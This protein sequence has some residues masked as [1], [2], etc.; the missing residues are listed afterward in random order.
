M[1]AHKGFT[2]YYRELHLEYACARVTHALTPRPSSVAVVERS[3]ADEGMVVAA[4]VGDQEVGACI[5]STLEEISDHPEARQ[6]GYV[7]GLY[8]A[9]SL[10]RQGIARH[11]L[12]YA[13]VRMREQ[14]CQGYWLT[15][16]ADN[17]PAQPLY[18]SLGFEIVD[19]SACFPKEL[20]NS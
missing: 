4:M 8:T 3:K 13:L 18:F 20:S 6:W 16:G 10:R 2:P 15:T 11:L 12:T 1:L 19:A 9:E 14:G 17:W 7:W 5:Y